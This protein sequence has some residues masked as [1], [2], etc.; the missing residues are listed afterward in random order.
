MRTALLCLF[1]VLITATIC[2]SLNPCP[3]IKI[4]SKIV[5]L[6]KT[7]S[8]YLQKS[9]LCDITA[10]VLKTEKGRTVCA[11]PNK[12]WVIK[13]MKFVEDKRRTVSTTASAMFTASEPTVI[14]TETMQFV[15]DKRRT[16]SSTA[17][18]MSTASEPTVITTVNHKTLLSTLRRL[19][20]HGASLE[21]FTSYLEGRSYQVTWRRLTCTLQRLST[22]V[23]QGSVLG[24]LLFCLYNPSLSKVISSHGF[25]YHYYAN[26]SQ[27]LLLPSLITQLLLGSQ[28][29]C[30]TYHH[31]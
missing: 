23:P 12:P 15:E 22:G 4:S 14:T 13:A 30:R 2:Q 18:A 1:A 21:W 28:H 19:G 5:P 27:L 10:A 9:A 29:I 20:I 8:Y 26:D 11:D 24:P 6:L 31:V 25:S 7:K 16:G 17:S 3:C